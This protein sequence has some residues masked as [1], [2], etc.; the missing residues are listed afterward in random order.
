MTGACTDCW[1]HQRSRGSALAG[2][3]TSCSVLVTPL[4]PNLARFALRWLSQSRFPPAT[5]MPACT[6]GTD[7]GPCT[8]A[9]FLSDHADSTWT[10]PY[11]DSGARTAPLQAACAV[12]S[13]THEH[14]RT[15][16]ET[17]CACCLLTP[18]HI[19]I[20]NL[21]YSIRQVVQRRLKLLLWPANMRHVAVQRPELC[22]IQSLTHSVFHSAVMSSV[23][24]AAL[25]HDT[26]RQHWIRLRV[27]V[28]YS[29]HC[30]SSSHHDH[31]RVSR[32][33]LAQ[34]AARQIPASATGNG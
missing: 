25:G 15:G 30:W 34:Q 6:P 14:W 2:V 26:V 28:M 5:C 8:Q 33:M 27:S 13:P 17:P 31:I 1:R 29:A 32:I 4:S 24:Q 16:A 22:Y 21:F 19:S 7:R 10:A 20:F 18:L 11:R 9:C 23:K 12:H 3:L